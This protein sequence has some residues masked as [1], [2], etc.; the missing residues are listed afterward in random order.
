MAIS[1]RVSPSISHMF[2]L[3]EFTKLGLHPV[4][5]HD[6]ICEHTIVKVFLASLCT[7][8]TF[9]HQL[10]DCLCGRILKKCKFLAVTLRHLR[11]IHCLFDNWNIRVHHALRAS[12]SSSC[13]RSTGFP[14]KM[15]L[16]RYDHE[17]LVQ[18]YQRFLA[19]NDG[20]MG[21]EKELGSKVT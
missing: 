20:C 11:C 10:H 12:R 9:L 3:F 15:C 18:M 17:F 5:P 2:I 13:S 19:C 4:Q 21:I 16:T 8:K 14:V 6:A 1:L 7:L